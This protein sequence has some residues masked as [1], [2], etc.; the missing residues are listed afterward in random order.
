MAMTVKIGMSLLLIF[1]TAYSKLLY[2]VE[3]C[4]L[5]IMLFS[6][7][8]A[9]P[10]PFLVFL[11]ICSVWKSFL[12]SSDPCNHCWSSSVFLS[13]VSIVTNR[14]ILYSFKCF[15]NYIFLWFNWSCND[16]SKPKFDC[17]CPSLLAVSICLRFLKF[18][19][20]IVLVLHCFILTLFV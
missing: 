16:C 9:I 18:A 10:P 5:T 3:S 14:S 13:Q 20:L 17:C 19:W 6:M 12:F 1:Q 4:C 11:L 7:V 8:S 15:E 2:S